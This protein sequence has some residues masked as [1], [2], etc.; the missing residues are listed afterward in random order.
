MGMLDLRRLDARTNVLENPFWITSGMLTPAADDQEAVF[1][2]FPAAYGDKV[3]LVQ[4]VCFET[5]IAFAGGTLA[6]KIGTG[7]IPLESSVD[8]ATV[9]PTDD[10]F[11]FTTAAIAGIASVGVSFPTAGA[12]VT[13]RG[14]GLDG[15]C[16]IV[17]ADSSVPVVYASL[18]SSATITA[19][20]G[21]LHML[22]SRIPAQ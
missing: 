13:A 10:D 7:T 21:R 18:T 12:F 1:F 2:S 3:Y 19:G 15:S 4:S 14:G 17:C 9:T 8:G 6:L 11:Y 20:A 22:L 16:D 5:V